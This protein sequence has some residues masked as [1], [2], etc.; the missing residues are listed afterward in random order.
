[1]KMLCAYCGEKKEYPKD[2]PVLHYAKCEDCFKKDFK[3]E[4]KKRKKN[5]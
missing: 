1:M 3:K 4:L 5:K 2:F